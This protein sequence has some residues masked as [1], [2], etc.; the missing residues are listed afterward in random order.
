MF[1]QSIVPAGLV[2]LL[3]VV[4][5]TAS[6]GDGADVSPLKRPAL[7]T[8]QAHRAAMMGVARAG[9]RLV[10]V[11]ERGV[12]LVSED[13]GSGWRQVPVPVSVTLTA[14]RFRD[15]RHGWATGHA[16]VVLATSDGGSTWAVQLDGGRASALALAAARARVQALAG[17]PAAEAGRAR[18]ALAAA[19]QWVDDGADKPFLDLHIVDANTVMVAGAHGLFFVTHDAGRTWTSALD[20]IDNPE[21]RHLNAIGGHG[22]HIVVAGEQ[23]LVLRSYDGGRRFV[24]IQTPLR[25]TWF[26][27][28]VAPSGAILLAGLRG[29]ALRSDATGAQWTRVRMPT[30]ATVTTLLRDGDRV[31]AG[32]QK[33]GLFESSDA[34]AGFVP[35]DLRSTA[36]LVAMTLARDGQP[37]VADLQ[38]VRRL[39]AKRGA[40]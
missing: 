4:P 1:F 26:A 33:G 8:A 23:G 28:D 12:V 2:L 11:G 21:G 39:L 30:D 13:Q 16:G 40:P 19:Q 27:V 24:A 29:N 25:S 6:S 18:Q 37:V 36:P 20:R 31:L 9:A 38:G 35:L 17:H 32:D 14:V 15:D 3:G 10:A 34:A 22:Q 5:G 7:Q